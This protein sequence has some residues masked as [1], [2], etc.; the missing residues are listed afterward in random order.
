MLKLSAKWV[1]KWL[2][3]D[4]NRQS[5]QLVVWVS[6][7]NFLLSVIQMISSRYGRPWKKLDYITVTRRQ[8]CG[9]KAA[10]PNTPEIIPCE[11]FRSGNSRL[12]CF[13][14]RRNSSHWL[15]SK[16]QTTN[17]EIYPSLSVQ[18]KDSLKEKRCCKITKVFLF[19]TTF[20][21]NGHL[22]SGRKWP[23][24]DSN[25]SITHPNLHIWHRQTTA[26]S[27]DCKKIDRSKF[28][29]QRRGHFYRANL[30]GRK[31]LSFFWVV[32]RS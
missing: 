17:A 18:L 10:H 9:G 2:N 20:P 32:Y 3:E 28:F 30:F 13:W 27:L 15:S 19:C 14:S 8:W 4:D 31:K 24:C 12:D 26:C 29:V 16:D 25:F 23:N 7:G 6:S 11:I 5:C 22:Q 21:V 1:P